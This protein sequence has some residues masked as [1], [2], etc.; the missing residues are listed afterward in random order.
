MRNRRPIHDALITHLLITH[1]SALFT[2]RILF[3]GDIVGKPGVAMVKRALP[4]LVAR[5]GIDLVIGNAENASGGSGLIP[6]TY[7]TLRQAGLDLMT[8]GDH[9]YK[10]QEIISLLQEEERI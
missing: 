10:K 6:N 3:L 5:E 7:R 1:H 9:I 8:M 4:P 2:M